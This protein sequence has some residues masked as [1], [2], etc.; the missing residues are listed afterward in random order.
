MAKKSMKDAAAQGASVFNVIATGNAQ[1]VENA[2]AVQDV[3]N[4]K[5]VK[6]K[7]Q[8]ERLNLKIPADIK[9]YLQ[10]AA[11]RESSA[12]I[13]RNTKTTKGGAAY[14]RIEKAGRM[15]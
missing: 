8:L 7:P 5:A 11:Y 14:G 1:N 3:P 2:Q 15:A 6:E 10:A 4:V 9:A 12:P 13:W